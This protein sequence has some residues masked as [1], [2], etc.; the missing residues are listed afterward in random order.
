LSTAAPAQLAKGALRR[1]AMAQQEPTPENY[2]RAYAEESG[3]ASTVLP[4][5]AR[6]LLERLVARLPE[7]PAKRD[8]LV[9]ALMGA[10]W[11]VASQALERSAHS[12]SAQA[13]AWA[14]LV[15]RLA[16][17]IERGSRQWT[18]GRKK[19]SLQRVLDGSRSDMQRLQQRL[20]ALVGAWESDAPLAPEAGE[21]AAPE[22]PLEAESADLAPADNG[23]WSGAVQ[24]L[25]RTVDAGLPAQEPRAAEFADRLA[26]LADRL[27]AEGPSVECLAELEATC[28]EIRRLFA[29]RQHLLQLLGQLCTEL[30][31]GLAELAEDESWA[32]GQAETLHARLAEGVNARSVRAASEILGETRQ[33]HARVR[34]ERD[35]ARNALKELFHRLLEEI[36]ELGEHT[37][38]F[39]ESVGRHAQAI[40]RAD[41][42]ETLAAVVR[43]MVDESRAVQQVV[44]QA[45][46]RMASEHARATE[47]EAKVRSLEAELRQLS[48]EVSTD[49]LTRVAN[50]RGLQQAFEAECSRQ[51]RQ[52]RTEG[53][54]A[55]A[56]ALIDIDNF[57]KLNDT[58]GHAAGDVALQSL[59]AAVRERLRPTDHLARF[60]GEEFVLLLPDTEL[61]AAQQSLTRLQRSLSAALFMHDDKEVFVTFSAGVTA[62]RKGEALQSALERADEALYEAKRTGKNRTCMA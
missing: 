11:D 57:K 16:R 49:A 21:A 27:S 43:E 29:H 36:G 5:R 1:L 26:A 2:A 42:I 47:L 10:R 8:E 14:A 48:D 46:D 22:A 17:A 52:Q 31:L 13:Q 12:A 56:V 18:P 20:G 3:Q 54:A 53:G 34:S 59:A 58:L 28:V 50:R 45:Q 41:S 23:S 35:Q 32:R 24:T 33:R 30:G 19:E 55:L 61:Q 37:G 25:R 38:R 40:E 9:A 39:Q 6:P 7:E 4:E 15:E 60:G 62:W 51:D 44:R